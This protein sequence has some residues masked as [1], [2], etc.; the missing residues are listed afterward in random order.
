MAKD[1]DDESFSFDTTQLR[2]TFSDVLPSND[3]LFDPSIGSSVKIL[4]VNPGTTMTTDIYAWD[5]E[6][7]HDKCNCEISF[8]NPKPTGVIY[9]N[10]ESD[11]EVSVKMEKINIPYNV[12]NT[13]VSGENYGFG[14]IVSGTYKISPFNG[15][16]KYLDGVSTL[17]MVIVQKHILQ[18]KKFNT[19]DKYFRAD[20]NNDRKI[21]V[22]D[23]LEIRRL[24]LGKELK[25]KNNVYRFMRKGLSNDSLEKEFEKGINEYVPVDGDTSQIDF[26]S[27]KTG[28]INSS[29]EDPMKDE[30]T[31]I[32]LGI[33]KEDLKINFDR[34]ER[35]G[36]SLHRNTNDI[37]TVKIRTPEILTNPGE[38]ICVPVIIEDY[39]ELAAAQ[40][41]LKYDTTKLKFLSI[42]NGQNMD[43]FQTVSHTKNGEIFILS[44]AEMNTENNNISLNACFEVI[45]ENGDQTSFDIN[46]SQGFENAFYSITRPLKY[47]FESG[48]V[49]IGDNIEF[50]FPKV[51]VGKDEDVCMNLKVKNFKDVTSFIL[52]I[53][54]DTDIVKYNRVELSHLPFLNNL[55]YFYQSDSSEL[56]VIW[57]SDDGNGK[58]M[59]D[60]ST[61]LS[62][63]FNTIGEL[64]TSSPIEFNSKSGLFEPSVMVGNN[65][66][67]ASFIDGEILIEDT[68][69]LCSIDTFHF[70]AQPDSCRKTISGYSLDGLAMPGD[71][72]LIDGQE[73]ITFGIGQNPTV[74]TVKHIDGSVSKCKTI[75]DIADTI[76]P[77][78]V[79]DTN[80]TIVLEDNLKVT[81]GAE[82]FDG[83]SYDN[84]SSVSF[85]Y[86][87]KEFDC[88]SPNPVEVTLSVSDSYGNVSK[89]KAFFNIE[90]PEA[91][92]VMVCND[93]VN[94]SV[95]ENQV[96]E[97]TADMILEGKQTCPYLY[98]LN[99]YDSLYSVVP[100]PDNLIDTSDIGNTYVCKVIHPDGENFCYSTIVINK[101]KTTVACVKT[102][103]DIPVPDVE[104]LDGYFTDDSGCVDLGVL[105]AGTV[106]KPQKASGED[107]K[108]MD[109]I[110]LA[111]IQKYLLGLTNNF[112]PYQKIAADFNSNGTLS[113][114]DILEIRKYILGLH[115]EES[116]IFVDASY[117]LPNYHITDYPDS[118][119]F[120]SENSK[121]DF[122]GILKGDVDFSYGVEIDH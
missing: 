56:L 11:S 90:Y 50:K 21:D 102:P 98:S 4:D 71:T 17:D 35:S 100:Q 81:Y 94:I 69:E 53:S 63:C 54:W 65:P 45:G 110:D 27:I 41:A 88:Y 26:I 83:G 101:E 40:F 95:I 80:K 77:V 23:V 6:N 84:C 72:I 24:I 121:Y 116:W 97:I 48:I 10:I 92:D 57:N 89:D 76:P 103:R 9:G 5:S 22:F 75:I 78:A 37:Q 34:T 33:T 59:L 111:M 82:Y 86:S 44:F 68:L 62:I 104:I 120:P 66:V 107:S 38:T 43:G 8:V 31:M 25:F 12:E 52:P 36:K 7:N 70:I 105:H 74:I 99:L 15:G 108:S 19:L 3:S 64:N 73:E 14:N 109:V 58:S 16:G 28:D 13:F 51:T 2:F 47:E 29:A 79:I 49:K 91:P 30:E 55:D 60:N 32:E 85:E 106:L 87:P 46:S 42:E 113:A 39:E 112:T 122:I 93:M 114:S 119:T 18:L 20:V 67:N 96:V 1:F 61:L 118:I 117:N 115:K